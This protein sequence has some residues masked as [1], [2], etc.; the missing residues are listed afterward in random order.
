MKPRGRDPSADDPSPPASEPVPLDAGE[1]AAPPLL[2]AG[3][4]S[5]EEEL[6]SVQQ[7]ALIAQWMQMFSLMT[8]AALAGKSPEP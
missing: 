2:V 7:I 6:F 1:L 3:P 5:S 4:V 8:R